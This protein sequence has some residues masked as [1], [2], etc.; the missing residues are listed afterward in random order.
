MLHSLCTKEVFDTSIILISELEMI[1][2]QSSDMPKLLILAMDNGQTDIT[3]VLDQLPENVK[4]IEYRL[5]KIS[6][7]QD[8]TTKENERSRYLYDKTDLASAFKWLLDS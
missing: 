4:T 8:T 1:L 5:S 2:R 7:Q 6:V 3:S